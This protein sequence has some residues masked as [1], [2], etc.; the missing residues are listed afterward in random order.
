VSIRVE[1]RPAAPEPAGQ[2]TGGAI[3]VAARWCAGAGRL[4]GRPA[5]MA[6]GT[7][8]IA[9]VL[10]GERR[11]LSLRRY[12]GADSS[13]AP[14]WDALGRFLAGPGFVAGYLGFDALWPDGLARDGAAPPALALFEPEAVLRLDAAAGGTVTCRVLQDGPVL[15]GLLPGDV[16]AGEVLPLRPLDQ[17]PRAYRRAVSRVLDSIRKGQAQRLTVARRVDLPGDIDLLASFAA[18]PAEDAAGLGRSYYLRADGLELAG[19]S[20]ELLGAGDHYRFVCHKLSGTGPRAL[21]GGEDA[22]LR[23]A[24][25]ADPKILEEHALSIAATRAALATLGA[26]EAG[27][28]RVVERRGLRHLLTPI[29]VDCRSGTTLGDILR[30]LLPAGAQPRDAG[31][32][33]LAELEA[34]TRG[35]YYGLI[36]LRRPDGGFEFSQ[37]LRTLFRDDTGVHTAVG[38]AVTGASTADGE[39]EETRLKL[40]DVTAVR[41]HPPA[42]GSGPA[43]R[44]GRP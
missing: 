3:G 22:A 42:R 17:D 33:L 35:A 7:P 27:A 31:L 30:V 26:A 25:L 36:G 32:R 43:P 15:S 24:L 18:P 10:V 29:A 6:F 41:P 14:L 38:A 37:V 4:P 8:D 9:H 23:A 1:R 40:D 39:W 11:R 21:A 34:G 19:H 16:P 2:P 12:A 44:P 28:M 5:T 20:P 13:A